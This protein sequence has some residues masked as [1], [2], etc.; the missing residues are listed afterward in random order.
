VYP[1][2]NLSN[3]YFLTPSLCW[4]PQVN[5]YLL[6]FMHFK[7]FPA[8]KWLLEDRTTLWTYNINI[9]FLTVSGNNETVKLLQTSYR[10]QKATV[11]KSSSR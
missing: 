9:K 6:T 5:Q 10:T 3:I 2:L 7:Y 1:L 11:W 4:F 8:N